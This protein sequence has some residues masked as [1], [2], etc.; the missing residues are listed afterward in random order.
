MRFLVKKTS[1]DTRNI[2]KTSVNNLLMCV[3]CPIRVTTAQVIRGL[4]IAVGSI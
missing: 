1:W 3:K 4:C 2:N